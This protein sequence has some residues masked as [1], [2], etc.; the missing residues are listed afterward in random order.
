MTNLKA[1]VESI[2]HNLAEVV[3]VNVFVADLG[4]LD[5][6]QAAYADYFPGGFAARRVVQVPA[7][8]EG[9]RVM[10]DAVVANAEG[11]PPRG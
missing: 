10:M 9:V 5:E 7:L 8:A 3:K 2:G 6:V 4:E 1:I 11:T